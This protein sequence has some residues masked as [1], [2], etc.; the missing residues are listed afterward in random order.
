M[1]TFIPI[2][3]VVIGIL[4]GS[5]ISFISFQY[6][7]RKSSRERLNKSLF[8]LLSVWSSVVVNSAIHSDL[9]KDAVVN[10]LKR[11]YP[12]ENIPDNFSDELAKSMR[13]MFPVNNH[14]ELYEKYHTS[15]ESLAEIDPLLAFQLSNNKFLIDYL[16]KLHEYSTLEQANENDGVFLDSFT[17]FAYKESMQEFENDLIKLSLLLGK[18]QVQEVKKRIERKKQKMA[19]IPDADMDEYIDQVLEPALK[20]IAGKIA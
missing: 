11:K 20:K 5:V 17:N 2:I 8:N 7:E 3:S 12:N 19:K 14:H 1:V 18:K 6:K 15:V 9:I 13:G 4:L 16:K 10:A